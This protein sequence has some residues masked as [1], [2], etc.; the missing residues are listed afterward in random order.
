MLK[1]RFPD[2][3]TD[4]T[5]EQIRILENIIASF[6]IDGIVY[7]E[8]MVKNSCRMFAGESAAKIKAEIIKE[9]IESM[10]NEMYALPN[11]EYDPYEW[12][13]YLWERLKD[14]FGYL[15]EELGTVYYEVKFMGEDSACIVDQQSNLCM[16]P[17]IYRYIKRFQYQYSFMIDKDFIL[18]KFHYPPSMSTLFENYKGDYK[19]SLVDFGPPVGREKL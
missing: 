10:N 15:A 11:Y 9:H 16:D 17:S 14:E 7:T 18:R 3:I 8:E 1:D 5:P 19:P 12:K 4:L 6:E 2:L 13:L